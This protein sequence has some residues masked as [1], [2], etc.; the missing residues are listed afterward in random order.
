MNA[1]WIDVF[2]DQY[3][4]ISDSQETVMEL[5][6][7]FTDDPENDVTIIEEYFDLSNKFYFKLDNS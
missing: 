6:K 3:L 2:G 1:Y 5:C 7:D 4:V